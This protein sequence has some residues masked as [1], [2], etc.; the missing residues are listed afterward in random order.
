[1]RDNLL[2]VFEEIKALLNRG[3]YQEKIQN[4]LAIL[5]AEAL[6]AS[7]QIR[8]AG[9]TPQEKARLGAFLEHCKPW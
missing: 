8:I 5:P 1:M 2:A 9:C 4:Q 7:R 3:R 6:K